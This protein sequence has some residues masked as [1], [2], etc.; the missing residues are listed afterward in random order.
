[1]VRDSIDLDR[2]QRRRRPFRLASIA[3]GS[4]IGFGGGNGSGRAAGG[5]SLSRIARISGCAKIL[6]KT[7]CGLNVQNHT[8][9]YIS[10]AP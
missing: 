5:S 3:L 9:R 10:F 4:P 1:L 8:I 6:S 2:I 7:F